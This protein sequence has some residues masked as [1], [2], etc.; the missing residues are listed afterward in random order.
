[1]TSSVWRKR[2]LRT[3]DFD[4]S[5]ETAEMLKK[6]KYRRTVSKQWTCFDLDKY[7][8]GSSS[9]E[10]QEFQTVNQEHSLRMFRGLIIDS[11][12]SMVPDENGQ[13]VP[14]GLN[15]KFIQDMIT[16]NNGMSYVDIIESVFCTK[17]D[18]DIGRNLNNVMR[19]DK[20]GCALYNVQLCLSALSL[21]PNYCN[22]KVSHFDISQHQVYSAPCTQPLFLDNLKQS[23][24]T[25]WLLHIVNFFKFH[26]KSGAEGLLAHAYSVLDADQYPQFWVGKLQAGTQTFGTHWKGAYMYLD[27]RTLMSSRSKNT[28]RGTVHT[29]S[30]DGGET[31]QDMSFFF[32]DA[33]YGTDKWPK[34]WERILGSDPF[35]ELGNLRTRYRR[36]QPER[37]AI[38]QFWGT[39]RGSKQGHFFGRI[40]A[41]AP[42]ADIP[43]FQRLVMMKFYTKKENGEQ[44]YDPTQVW[45]YE[46]VVLPGRRIVVGRWW[47]ARG[48]ID[49]ERINSGPFIWWNVDRSGAAKPI[50]KDEAF[51]F[52]DSFQD[53]DLGVV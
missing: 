52:L 37:P 22:A 48:D 33:Q 51:D 17:Y 31:F 34:Q 2:F 9:Y 24:N 38:K 45:A 7:G 14:H 42:Q 28:S 6:Y 25:R 35:K 36:N 46:G 16:G 11:N 23:V 27:Q 12:A 53:H 15:L 47:D 32:D 41:M 1:V 39:S 20:Q 30:L 13:L 4:N 18:K 50:D 26:F 29:D 3:F 5:L 21:H 44:V 8:G 40:H 10:V 49:D 19:L 43:G